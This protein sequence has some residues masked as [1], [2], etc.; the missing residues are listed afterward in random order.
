[1]PDWRAEIRQRLGDTGLRAE[2]DIVEE[3]SQ[4]LQDRYDDLRSQGV[5][6]ADAQRTALAELEDDATL[7][8]RIRRSVPRE[9][10][11]PAAVG[12]A[13]RS[14]F[15]SG[16]AGDLRLAV[17]LLRRS[18]GFT[19]VA[20]LVI[21]LGIG[22]NT[23]IFSVLNA[24][25][26]RPL[27][28]VAEPSRLAAVYTSDYSGPR[29]GSSSYADYLAMRESGAFEDMASYTPMPFSIS[30]GERAVRGMGEAVSANY[31]DVLGVRPLRG[32]FFLP[33]EAGPPGS[34]PVVVLSH[35]FWQDRLGSADDVIGR[36]LRINGELLTV[37]GVAPESFRGALR[38]LRIDAWI[39]PGAPASLVGGDYDP[40]ARGSRGLLLFGRLAAG[41]TLENS[42]TRLDGL[43][44]QLHAAYPDAWTDVRDQ[45]RVI[46]ALSEADM[47]VP[48]QVRG[49]VVGFFGLMMTVVGIVLLIACTNV[50]N[51]MLARAAARRAE[52]GV[53]IAIGAS[54][55]RIVR[56]LLTESL[57]IGLIGGALGI[58]AAIVLTRLVNA[59][60]LPVPVPVAL[61]V[62]L[63]VR[64]L[65]FAA[66]ITM[67]AGV[68]FGIVPALQSSR[69]PAPLMKDAVS[70]RGP[71]MRLR[72]ALVVVQVAASL[73]LLTGGAIFLRSLLVAQQID[74]GIDT[75]NMLLV[76]FDLAIEGMSEDE[77]RRFYDEARAVAAA[78][79]GVRSVTLAERVPLG[80]G[81]AR[82]YVRV[83]GYT[84]AQGED[85]EVPFN[86][87]SDGYFEG[88]G[89]RL[90]RGRGFTEAD[91]ADAP[92]VVV[93]NEAFA[94]R[95]WPGVG[96]LGK[97]VGMGGSDAPFAEVVGVV[98]DGKYRS[99]TE[100]PLPY[101]YYP[102]AQR[103]SRTMTMQVRTALDPDVVA[104]VLRARLRALAPALPVPEM[105]TLR[106]H[107][108]FAT[109]PQRA[110]AI[111]L[112][113]LGVIALGI[114]G[115]GLYG[116]VSYSVAQRTREFGIRNALG[117]AASDV[118]RMVLVHGLRLAAI[119]VAAGLLLA[120]ALTWV[121]RSML[122]VSPFDPVALVAGA[123]VLTGAAALASWVPARRAMRVNPLAAL[124]MDV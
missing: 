73:V 79:P 65:L 112:A 60:P 85:M 90:A 86:G 70:A 29:Y 17:R 15:L 118:Q 5:T 49:A 45:A 57:L 96:A 82:R 103:P 27:P 36:T 25:L 124:R 22:A 80:A 116:V 121:I 39:A 42:Q 33:P 69:A 97:R 7:G 101:L 108:S 53:R 106:Q 23:A 43:A 105:T 46:T 114:A 76:P 75:G 123:V 4:H 93:V 64:V 87:V 81:W 66:G 89:I 83:E 19:A 104:P 14:G 56:Q 34:A 74:T 31:F 50:A 2:A 55:G 47:R 20:I 12:A 61:D 38:G 95:F 51:L 62:P 111:V 84:P 68:L 107:V 32:R 16:M 3:L 24:V 52:M 21:A 9:S 113:V 54:R 30:L 88:M 109:L 100:E 110:A 58:A 18:P 37:I 67:A 26:L 63:D 92:R 28:G 120:L 59:V 44:A 48:P 72:N 6:D 78:V 40:D 35:G 77:A 10:P 98:P 41:A 119:G 94:R 122:L 91:R 117:A 99:L 102:Y 8:A 13:G 1:M 71:R 11:P 115:I